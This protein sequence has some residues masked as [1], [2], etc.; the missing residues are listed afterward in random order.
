VTDQPSVEVNGLAD[1]FWESIL[2]LQP[3]T[4]TMYGDER[5]ADRLEDPSET[6]RAKA[7]ALWRSARREAEAIPTEGLSV[8][9]RITIDMIKVLCDLGIEEHEQRTD[10]L[11]VVDQ[12]GGPQTLLPVVTQFQPADTP[13]RFEK[14]TARL[15]AYPA[16]MA[17]NCDLLREGLASGLTAPRIVVERTIAQLE[18]LLEIPV[19]ESPIATMAQVATEADRDTVRDIVRDVVRPAN[20]AFLESLRGPYLAASREDPGL[21]SAP[22]GDALYRTQIRAWTTVDMDPQ[23][24][25]QIGLDELETIE[26]ERRA[27]SQALGYGDDTVALRRALDEDPSNTPKTKDELLARAREDI[28]RALAIAPRYF[29]VLPRAGVEVRP[30]EEFKEADS[31]FA[32]Y[33]AP[34]SDGSRGGSYYANG[35]DLPSRKYTKLATTTY[36]E[37][38]PGHHF[39]IALEMENESLNTFRRLGSRMVGS[40]YVEGWGLYSERLADEMGLFRSEAE[41]FGMLDAQAWR[42]A[43]LVVDTGL[44]ALRWTRQRSIDFLLS[45]G[46]SPTDATIE[47]DRYIAWPGQALTYKLGQRAIESLRRDL[48][49]RDG[50]HFDLR[51]FHDQVLGHG[52]LPLATLARE[53]PTWVTTPASA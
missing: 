32:Y 25:H 48:T 11:R 34:A 47:T 18:R 7:L 40:A 53:L 22:N 31:P 36:H 26:T 38:V 37:A 30:V 28:E 42:A 23:H 16:Y 15:H 51:E 49:A 1:R 27:I 33:Y 21:W 20:E 29:G 50:A 10:L 24:I 3:T 45:T 14:Y 35:Y 6:G 46:L 8:E 12:M 13:E 2:E 5:Y 39:Q 17:A 52:S 44:H 9:D 43:R 19:V 4:A 41:R